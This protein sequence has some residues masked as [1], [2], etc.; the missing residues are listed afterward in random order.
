MLQFSFKNVE[1]ST[2]LTNIDT[3]NTYVQSYSKLTVR[4]AHCLY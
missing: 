3:C 4:I 2:N 1:C